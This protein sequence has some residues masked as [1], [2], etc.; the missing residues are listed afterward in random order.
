[1]C[2]MLAT[3]IRWQFSSVQQQMCPVVVWIPLLVTVYYDFAPDLL[4]LWLL[5]TYLEAIMYKV[6]YYVTEI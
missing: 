1:M 2:I 6:L 5:D 4:P 3:W